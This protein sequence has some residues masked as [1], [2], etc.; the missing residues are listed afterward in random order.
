MNRRQFI[1]L[2]AAFALLPAAKRRE[3][4]REVI[5]RELEAAFKDAYTELMESMVQQIEY[6]QNADIR[7]QILLLSQ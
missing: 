3:D 5:F 2:A 1:G 7:A 4:P 6:L